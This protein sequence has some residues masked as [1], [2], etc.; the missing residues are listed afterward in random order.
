MDIRVLEKVQRRATKLVRGLRGMTYEQRLKRLNLS[1]LEERRKR[2]D[3]IEYFK[4]SNGLSIVNWHNPNE[5]C[6]SITASGP[7]S[8]IRGYKHRVGKQFTKV[9]QREHFLL[10]RVVRD[11]NNLPSNVIQATS[12]NS[13]KARLDDYNEKQQSKTNRV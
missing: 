12:A 3:L 9:S 6:C 4:I 1:T 8:N 2:A 5:L 13:F 10:K 11:W 7:A